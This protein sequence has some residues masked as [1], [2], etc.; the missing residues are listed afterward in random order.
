MTDLVLALLNF[1]KQFV[2]ETNASRHELGA[3][4][5]QNHHP[6]AYF[7]HVL[8]SNALR[9]S[10]YEQKLMAIVFAVQK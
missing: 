8:P 1:S 6:I 9:K 5:M 4:L 3:I 2:I 7:K 10:I